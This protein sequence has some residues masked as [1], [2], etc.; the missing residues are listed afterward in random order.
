MTNKLLKLRDVAYP[1]IKLRIQNGESCRFWIDNWSPYGKLQ[2]YLEGGRSRLVIPKNATMASLHRN[3][4]WNLPAAWSEHQ[5]QVISF[6]TTIQFNENMDY[7]AW[8]INGRISSKFSTWE[9]YHYL[10]GDEIAE[11]WTRA[12]WTPRSIPRQSFHAWLVALNRLPTRNRLIGWGLQVPPVCL[13]V[14]PQMNHETISI[15]SA[16]SLSNCGLKWLVG[17][18]SARIGVGRTRSIKWLLCL[19]QQ[20]HDL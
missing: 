3:G 20:Q 8:E 12:I 2:D 7:Y 18:E 6:I 4:S 15:G 13:F 17:A 19:L 16:T 1:F 14:T 9:V 5:L 11:P 10:R